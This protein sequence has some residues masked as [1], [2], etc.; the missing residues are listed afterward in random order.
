MAPHQ[1][2]QIGAFSPPSHRIYKSPRSLISSDVSLHVA[3]SP[4]LAAP[5]G[6]CTTPPHAREVPN[7]H[8]HQTSKQTNGINV[9]TSNICTG[10]SKSQHK[11]KHI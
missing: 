10:I 9:Y 11:S 4:S 5:D 2:H 6:L 8:M 7:L 1:G 3:V